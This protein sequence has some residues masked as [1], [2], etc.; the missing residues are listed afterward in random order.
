M[1]SGKELPI[2]IIQHKNIRIRNPQKRPNSSQEPHN[3]HKTSRAKA[4]WHKN[5]VI[6]LRHLKR[7][8]PAS[9]STPEQARASSLQ[10]HPRLNHVEQSSNHCLHMQSLPLHIHSSCSCFNST[11]RSW[12]HKSRW[13]YHVVRTLHFSGAMYHT[14]TVSPQR[15][16]II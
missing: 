11:V 8:T 13:N 12:A 16:R 14:A 5:A 2:R 7:P 15:K 3:R 10:I 4:I 1:L 6:Y 9:Q